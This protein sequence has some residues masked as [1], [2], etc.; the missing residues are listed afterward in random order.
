M[1]PAT[2][3]RLWPLLVPL[4]AP[5]SLQPPPSGLSQLWPPE[6]PG[7]PLPEAW[8]SP[9]ARSPHVSPSWE[10]VAEAP[11][12]VQPLQVH[13]ALVWE[14]DADG[15]RLNPGVVR[16]PWVV[17]VPL[18]HLGG[19]AGVS[20][21]AQWS[22]E[23]RPGELPEGGAPRVPFAPSRPWDALGTAVRCPRPRPRLPAWCI[24]LP[25]TAPAPSLSSLPGSGPTSRPLEGLKQ[26]GGPQKHEAK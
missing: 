26:D 2:L 8:R 16:V 4:G 12:R 19:G 18:V 21:S 24:L 14:V 25:N 20:W 23:P 10:P 7:R 9:R 13:V 5:D 17:H 6:T 3:T 1:N 22:T 15:H 11:Y